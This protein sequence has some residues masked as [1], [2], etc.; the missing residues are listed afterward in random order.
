[1]WRTWKRKEFVARGSRAAAGK[2][3]S[4]EGCGDEAQGAAAPSPGF[5]TRQGRRGRPLPKGGRAD[6]ASRVTASPVRTPTRA[7]PQPQRQAR[8]FRA[9]TCSD[10][11]EAWRESSIGKTGPRVGEPSPS[12]RPPTSRTARSGTTC[13]SK[14]GRSPQASPIAA[15]RIET[16]PTP[17]GHRSPYRAQV[18]CAPAPPVP[19]RRRR[20]SDFAVD[21]KTRKS[22]ADN[23]PGLAVESRTPRGNFRL[24]RAQPSK[25]AHPLRSPSD[26]IP[27]RQLVAAH[28]AVAG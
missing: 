11:R 28:R 21:V 9:A 1:M 24:N 22:P 3:F 23:T 17:A 19:D 7:M 5:T 25:S 15:V 4:L 12:D 18:P 8:T 13:R 16:S 2:L 14:P 20:R 27:A 10:V 6:S 26:P